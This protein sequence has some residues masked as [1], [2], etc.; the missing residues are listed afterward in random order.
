MTQLC[1]GQVTAHNWVISLE[2]GKAQGADEGSVRIISIK[3]EGDKIF[4]AIAA[5]AGRAA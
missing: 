5:H 2:T 1:S 3:V 4:I